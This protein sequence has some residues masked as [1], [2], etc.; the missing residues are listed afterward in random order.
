MRHCPLSP[1]PSPHLASQRGRGAGMGKQRPTNTPTPSPAAHRPSW[2]ILRLAER[3]RRL[4]RSPTPRLPPP[5]PVCSPLPSGRPRSGDGRAQAEGW[6][7]PRL[8]PALPRKLVS[9]VVR[10]TRPPRGT[11]R[12]CPSPGHLFI[13]HLPRD[14]QAVGRQVRCGWQCRVPSRTGTLRAG[15]ALHGCELNQ[16]PKRV[17]RWCWW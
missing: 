12:S 4:G 3:G 2:P 13:E 7:S 8:Y 15:G 1:N 16:V 14:G 11:G 17:P 5:P 9:P 6:T 10:G